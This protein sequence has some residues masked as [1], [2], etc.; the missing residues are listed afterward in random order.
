MSTNTFYTLGVVLALIFLLLLLR[1]I[2]VRRALRAQIASANQHGHPRPL[3]VVVVSGGGWR[4]GGVGGIGHR[5]YRLPTRPPAT[6]TTGRQRGGHLGAESTEQL[7]K[8]EAAPPGYDTIYKDGPPPLPPVAQQE[9]GT[10]SRPQQLQIPDRSATPGTPRT[11]TPMTPLTPWLFRPRSDATMDVRPSPLVAQPPT[12][13]EESRP[14]PTGGIW[15][16]L[17]GR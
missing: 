15:G 10:T 3:S 6:A 12:I 9:T 13:V 1:R 2:F 11:A 5:D 14:Q 8:Y 16:R 17:T 4:D 7:P